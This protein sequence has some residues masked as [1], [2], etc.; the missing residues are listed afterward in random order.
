MAKRKDPSAVRLAVVDN[1]E[2][3]TPPARDDGDGSGGSS[4]RAPPP[5]LPPECPLIPI[6]VNGNLRYY[7]DQARQLVAL[8]AGKHTRLEMTALY[9]ADAHLVTPHFPRYG[10][11]GAINGVDASAMAEALFRHT[12]HRGL[13]SPTEKARGRGCWPTDSGELIVNLGTAV[14]AN[15]E[16]HRPGLFG[17]YVLVA[18]EKIMTPSPS[19]EPGGVSGAGSEVLTLL[20]TWAWWRPI[21]ARLLLGWLVCAFLG[22][23]LPIRPVGWIIGARNTGKSTLQTAISGLAGGWLMSVLD[24]SPASIWQSLRYDCLAVGIDE[25]EPDADKDNQRK[26]AELVKLARMCY[27]GGKLT[28]GGSDGEPTEYSLRSAVLFSSINQPPLLPQDRSRMILMRLAK[29][30][31]DQR[32]P[33]LH[34]QRLR[35]LGARLLRRAIDGHPRLTA[36]L[37]QYRIALKAV[38]HEGRTVEVFATALAAADIVLSDDP[39]DTDSAA[40]LA[41]QLDFASLP[42]AEDDLPDE[43]AWLAH[44]LSCV[45]PL[46]GVGGRNT[47]AAWL[48]Q[49]VTGEQTP[50]LSFGQ[51]DAVQADADRVLGYYG[52]KIIRPKEGG[53]PEHFAIA[54]RASGLERLHAGTHWAGRSGAIGGW[55]AAARDLEGAHETGQRFGGGPTSKGTAVPLKIV[56]PEGYKADIPPASERG[57]RPVDVDR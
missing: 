23:A 40:E 21:D 28:R 42:E 18:R 16:W 45:I 13:W 50:G 2:P 9:G 49:G 22:A 52:I 10:K 38:G 6:G 3:V 53:A 17:D 26:L 1:A 39:V 5:P 37:E 4:R 36:A 14:L 41:A 24:P 20:Q 30:P 7:L 15:G 35:L 57:D 29:F 33:D 44:L 47:I 11:N 43:Q 34:P 54:N 19:G 8:P 25:A 46:D 27:S 51:L 48:R 32:E 56:F 31:K 55:K 12:G